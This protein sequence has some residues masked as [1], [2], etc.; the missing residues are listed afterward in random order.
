MRET[1][2][3][4]HQSSST[5][6]VMLAAVASV[7]A[8]GDP[9]SGAS[10]QR[11]SGTVP[12]DRAGLFQVGDARYP[13]LVVRCDLTGAVADGILLR[14]TGTTPDNRRMAVEVERVA[15]DGRVSERASVYFGRAADGESWTARRYQSRIGAWF[16]DEAGTEAADGPLLEIS[17]NEIVAAGGYR[18]GR[19]GTTR[20]GTL[21]AVCPAQSRVR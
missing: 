7:C 2:R 18:H 8:C 12:A 4:R 16:A 17:K 3:R 19:N 9:A 5:L 21:R 13:F 14:G 6:T 20:V 15:E 11:Q 1:R 10:A